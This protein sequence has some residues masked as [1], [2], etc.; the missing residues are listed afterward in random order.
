[1]IH[2]IRYDAVLFNIQSQTLNETSNI[3]LTTANLS[4]LYAI[5][6]EQI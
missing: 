4:T 3:L 6:T 2:V 5:L 1:M